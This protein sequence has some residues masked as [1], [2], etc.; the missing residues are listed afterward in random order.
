MNL[1]NYVSKGSVKF[2]HALMFYVM[3][4]V[5]YA[6]LVYVSGNMIISV[7]IFNLKF[8]GIIVTII[9]V[10]SNAQLFKTRKK[11]FVGLPSMVNW[12]NFQVY[13]MHASEII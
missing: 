9:K 3:M 11:L 12:Y 8:N 5:M 13:A 7:I 10:F 2:E 4:L 6:S 1:I